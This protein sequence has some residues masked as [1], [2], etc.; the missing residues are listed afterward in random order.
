ME[1]G[2]AVGDVPMESKEVEDPLLA[3]ISAD[4]ADNHLSVSSQDKLVAAQGAARDYDTHEVVAVGGSRQRS[5]TP[6]ME[7]G[8]DG[9]STQADAG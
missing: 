3:N 4:G 6:T 9:R 8:C 7:R 5:R 2:A 1:M